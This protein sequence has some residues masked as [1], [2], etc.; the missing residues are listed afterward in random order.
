MWWW[1]LLGPR[2]GSDQPGVTQP[3]NCRIPRAGGVPSSCLSASLFFLVPW[4]VLNSQACRAGGRWVES[5]AWGLPGRASCITTHRLGAQ[6][7][8]PAPEGGCCTWHRA[9]IPTRLPLNSPR[10]AG[11]GSCRPDA[12]DKIPPICPGEWN[13]RPPPRQTLPLWAEHVPPSWLLLPHLGSDNQES[14]G[15]ASGWLLPRPY[16]YPVS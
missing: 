15:V 5:L 16:Q 1:G 14:W 7:F 10:Q 12:G 9:H 8:S 6:H 13:S 2:V 3:V 4:R 11:L